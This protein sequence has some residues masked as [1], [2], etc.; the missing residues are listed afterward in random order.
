MDPAAP[1]KPGLRRLLDPGARRAWRWLL[2]LLMAA[3]C[4]LAFDPVPSEALSTGWD[5][6]NHALAFAP[7]GAV[8]VLAQSPSRWRWVRAAAAMLAFGGFIE[9]VQTRIPGRSGE[10]ADLLADLIGLAV[11]LALLRIGLRRLEA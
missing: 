9:V 1:A 3:V 2:A 7:L 11:G 6:L 4:A 5:K 8:A 10:V